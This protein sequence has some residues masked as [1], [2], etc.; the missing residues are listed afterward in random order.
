MPPSRLRRGYVDLTHE[1]HDAVLF[2]DDKE[3]LSE[4]AQQ[5]EV[6]T[7]TIEEVDK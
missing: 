3:K 2:V 7:S 1:T 6:K 5:T 4:A